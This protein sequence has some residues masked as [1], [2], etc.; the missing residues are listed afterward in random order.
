MFNFRRKKRTH[1]L[2]YGCGGFGI[3]V[4]S[5]VRRLG[6]VVDAYI[7]DDFTI[8]EYDDLQVVR[9]SSVPR[10]SFIVLGIGNPLARKKIFHKLLATGFSRKNFPSV[11]DP[12]AEIVGN[13]INMGIGVCLC[14]GITITSNIE[15]SDFSVV[16]LNSTIGHRSRIG[17]YTNI[18]PLVAVSGNCTIGSGC[19]IGT[20]SSIREKI[21]I[22]A[23]TII[24]AG[25]VVVKNIEVPGTYI[26][27][28]AKI[29][30]EGKQ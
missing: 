14:A 23:D 6:C 30:P 13:N 21:S 9:A 28:P 4:A 11:V 3:E 29:M 18:A 19:F 27:V 12:R 25:S 5:L 15:L 26:G 20:G 1:V 17:S 24:G 10:S 8:K 2:I 16:N 7:D 22:C